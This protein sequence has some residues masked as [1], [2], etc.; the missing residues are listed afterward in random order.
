MRAGDVPG[1]KV[2]NSKT[3]QYALRDYGCDCGQTYIAQP[4]AAINPEGCD[5]EDDREQSHALGDHAMGML[6]LYPA[7]HRR[8]LVNRSKGSRPVGNGQTGVL[9]GNQRPGD[10]QEKDAD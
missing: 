5:A 1:Q 4:L 7:N 2:Q 10:N 6:E 8:N 3:A 9:T